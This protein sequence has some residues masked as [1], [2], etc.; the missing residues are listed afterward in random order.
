MGVYCKKFKWRILVLT[1]RVIVLRFSMIVEYK[2]NDV[3][4]EIQLSILGKHEN[5]KD[6]TFKNVE[7]ANVASITVNGSY[8]QMT[9]V[10]EAAAKWIE[11]EGYEL[12]GPMFNIYHVS[13]AMESDPNKWV[14]EVCYPVK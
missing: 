10:N 7:S 8:E 6:V 2:E 13:P 12:A 9:A 11:T 14:T 3:D 4:I 5:T 1:I